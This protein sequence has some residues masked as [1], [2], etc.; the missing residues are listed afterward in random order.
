MNILSV[1]PCAA[2]SLICIFTHHDVVLAAG[3]GMLTANWPTRFVCVVCSVLTIGF[4]GRIGLLSSKVRMDP[5]DYICPM[6]ISLC[7]VRMHTVLQ[8]NNLVPSRCCGTGVR[9][10]SGVALNARNDV[11]F[12]HQKIVVLAASMEIRKLEHVWEAL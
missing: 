3:D 2:V 4:L 9:A 10:Q 7:A 1:A 5:S 8:L 6:L 12:P 11:I